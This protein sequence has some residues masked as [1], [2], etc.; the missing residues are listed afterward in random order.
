MKSSWVVL[1]VLQVQVVLAEWHHA[2][3][4]DHRMGDAAPLQ[5]LAEE[6]TQQ[7]FG[8]RGALDQDAVARCHPRGMLDQDLGIL[9]NA[10]IGHDASSDSL[11]VSLFRGEARRII[12]WWPGVYSQRS[13]RTVDKDRH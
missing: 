2:R 6:L 4:V 1:C 3:Q 9:L 12:S 11:V 5:D 10:Q 7:G 8:R 13:L